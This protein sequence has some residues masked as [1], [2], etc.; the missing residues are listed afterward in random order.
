MK[1]QTLEKERKRERETRAFREI[2]LLV[3]LD[4]PIIFRGGAQLVEKR[5]VRRV[6]ATRAGNGMLNCAPC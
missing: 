6:Y 2:R 3:N 1:V 5:N 4:N